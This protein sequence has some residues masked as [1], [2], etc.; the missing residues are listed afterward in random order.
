MHE[1]IFG[2]QTINISITFL[3]HQ[4]HPF[5]SLCRG[6][7]RILGQWPFPTMMK[8]MKLKENYLGLFCAHPKQSHQ[9]DK[10]LR[11]RTCLH[12]IFRWQ[13]SF[14]S[15]LNA[16]THC[17]NILDILLGKS[18]GFTLRILNITPAV[19]AVLEG[20]SLARAQGHEGLKLT[21]QP[22]HEACVVFHNLIYFLSEV[23]VQ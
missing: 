9:A 6:K 15:Q 16:W 2:E 12:Q 8:S 18:H 13:R 21:H 7:S 23:P 5:P 17:L 4:P 14:T 3:L 20:S 11:L 1:G 22:E 10:A 19:A